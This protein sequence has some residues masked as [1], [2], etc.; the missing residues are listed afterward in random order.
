[1]SGMDGLNKWYVDDGPGGVPRV[2]LAWTFDAQLQ[3]PPP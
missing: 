3:E 2:F 1:M